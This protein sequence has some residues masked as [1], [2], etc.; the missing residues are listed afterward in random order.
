[1]KTL[2]LIFVSLIAT[3][4]V[5]TGCKKEEKAPPNAAA[6]GDNAKAENAFASAIV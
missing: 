6:A 1:M 3:T 2:K 5:F 4:L